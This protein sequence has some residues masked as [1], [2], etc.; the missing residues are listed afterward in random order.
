MLGRKIA[1]IHIV[2]GGSQN[3]LLNQMT[4]DACGRTVIAGPTEATAAGNVMVQAMAIGL[5]KSLAE[6]RGIVRA[7]LETKQFTPRDTQKWDEA[8]ARFEA[9]AVGG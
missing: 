7:S 4:A 5:V 9:V 6:A 3:E 2:G 1:V 8:Y